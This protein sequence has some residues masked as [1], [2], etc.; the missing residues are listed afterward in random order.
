MVAATP[1]LLAAIGELVV[2]QAGVLNLGRRGH[3][4]H[5][6]D[7][8]L[9]DRGRNRLAPAGLYRRGHRRGGS[10]LLFALP[11]AGGTGQSGRLGSGADPL[12]LGLSALLGQSY[13]GVKPPRM[14]ERDI[15]LSAIFRS[16]ARSF[17]PRL[18]VYL[19]LALVAAVWATLKYTR[20]GLI[21]RAVG[22]NHDAAHA[23]GYKVVAI[24]TLAILFGGACAGWAGPISA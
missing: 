18:I 1:I 10:V 6:R 11:D 4:D 20:A 12:R 3:D 8:R 7:L 14:G 19:G 24:R 17:W 22:E 9:C 16:S 21:L 15:P 5:R 13:V 23:L 2:E